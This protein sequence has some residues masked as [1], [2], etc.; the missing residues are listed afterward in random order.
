MMRGRSGRMMHPPMHRQ[1]RSSAS[2]YARSVR[3]YFN[4]TNTYFPLTVGSWWELSGEE[5]GAEI[6]L[7]I[8]VL[9]QTETVGGVRTLVLKET[10]Y[11]NG[12]LLEESWNYFAETADGTVCYFGE[13]VNI[14]ENGTVSHEGAWRADDPNNSPGIFMPANPRPGVSFVMEGAPNVAE[15]EGTIVSISSATVP[16]GFFANVIRVREFNPLDAGKDY[17]LYA[18]GVGLIID[19]PLSLDAYHI[20]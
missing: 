11:V 4:S 14:Y 6:N 20:Q 2:K 18:A 16:A 19:G 8:D 15:D 7:R 10:E 17:K 1:P 3:T 9:R 5:D 13:A 12:A